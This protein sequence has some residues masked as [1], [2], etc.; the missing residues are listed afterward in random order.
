MTNLNICDYTSYLDEEYR[1]DVISKLLGFQQRLLHCNG[2]QDKINILRQ[3]YVE[4]Y[5]AG[6]DTFDTCERE[7]LYHF[8]NALGNSAELNDEQL[9]ECL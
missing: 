8:C 3:C 2:V 5:I 1:D 9:Q 4:T 7:G 6:R